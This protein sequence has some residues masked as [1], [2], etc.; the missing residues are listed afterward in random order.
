MHEYSGITKKKTYLKK[1]L[2]RQ[3]LVGRSNAE[4]SANERRDEGK[5]TESKYNLLHT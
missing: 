5:S 4:K 1:P 3:A 2:C